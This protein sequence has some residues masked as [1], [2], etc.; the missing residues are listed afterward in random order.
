VLTWG[1]GGVG[2][3]SDVLAGS[4]ARSAL[5]VFRGLG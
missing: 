4:V 2:S 5:D 1:R 3:S